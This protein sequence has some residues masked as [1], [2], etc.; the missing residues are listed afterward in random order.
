MLM[1]DV[2]I[3]IIA[4]MACT[5]KC[6]TKEAFHSQLGIHVSILE[7]GYYQKMVMNVNGYSIN[8]NKECSKYESKYV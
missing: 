6:I 4:F 5:W 2:S 1:L 7:Q 8:I 3:K